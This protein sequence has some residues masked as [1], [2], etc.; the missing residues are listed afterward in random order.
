[1]SWHEPT[2][3]ERASIERGQLQNRYHF[4][5]AP[6]PDPAKCA[7]CGEPAT[8]ERKSMKLADGAL[9]HAD[10]EWRCLILY[11]KRWR[12]EA[13]EGLRELGLL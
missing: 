5:F 4:D 1:M 13:D 2:L 11:G 7:G 6:P 10:R 3:D 9:V 8:R 12:E